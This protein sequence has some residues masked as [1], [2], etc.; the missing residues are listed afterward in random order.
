MFADANEDEP[1]NSFSLNW[2]G[3]KRITKA[4]EIVRSIDDVVDESTYSEDESQ[5]WLDDVL[6]RVSDSEFISPISVYEA[7]VG[8]CRNV[9]ENDLGI[10]WITISS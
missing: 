6:Q 2:E 4:L 8:F 5:K 9:C 10:W 7:D 3:D 1:V